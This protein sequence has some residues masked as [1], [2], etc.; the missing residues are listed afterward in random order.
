MYKLDSD[1]ITFISDVVDVTL[2][3]VID[4]DFGFLRMLV[5]NGDCKFSTQ[6]PQGQDA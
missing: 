4:L 5:W 6:C 3:I 2:L 1:I